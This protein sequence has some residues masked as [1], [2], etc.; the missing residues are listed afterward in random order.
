MLS[1]ENQA[2]VTIIVINEILCW[3]TK[4]LLINYKLLGRGDSLRLHLSLWSEMI[5]NMSSQLPSISLNEIVRA[6]WVTASGSGKSVTVYILDDNENHNR[7]LASL[8]TIWKLNWAFGLPH[9]S[10]T[11]G[12]YSLF[13]SSL[14]EAT[15]AKFISWQVEPDISV[16]VK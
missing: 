5:L 11:K 12:L 10:P 1:G 6:V 14:S 9:C 3:I 4:F 13:I 7:K 2:N 15:L 16:T 8:F